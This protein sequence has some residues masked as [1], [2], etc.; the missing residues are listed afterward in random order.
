MTELFTA[1]HYTNGV[2][3]ITPGTPSNNTEDAPSGFSSNDPGQETSYLAERVAAAVKRGDG[4]NGDLLSA[5]FGLSEEV[6]TNLT[7]AATIEQRGAQEMNT[8]LWQATL[9][10]FLLQML[11]VGETSD[12]PVTDDDIAWVRS[13]FIDFVRANGPLPAIRVG[14]QPYGVL[15]VTSLDAW[16]PP[17]GE[18]SQFQ[19]DG[20]LRD[21][22]IRLRDIWR[23]NYEDVPRLGRTDDSPTEKGIDKDLI[24]V[25]SMDGLSSSYS[26]R[27]LM[28]RHYLE[29]LL[30]FMSADYFLDI[31]NNPGPTEPPEEEAPELEEPDP[32]LQP[33]FRAEFIR[34]QREA[35]LAFQRRQRDRALA[36][37]RERATFVS[38]VNNKRNSINEWWN[39][40]ERLA[41]NVLPELGIT[42]RPRLAHGVFAPPVTTLTGALVQAD[43]SLTL[44][45]NYIEALLAARDLVKEVRFHDLSIEQ[46]P[47]HTLLHLLLRHSMLLEYTS[48]GS[49]LLI[50]RGLL[51]RAQRRE[52]ELVDLPVGHLML[53]VWRQMAT[54][55]TVTDAGEMEL[56]HYL[57]G[58]TPDGE[59]DL[60]R[61]PDLKQVSEFRASLAH[62]KSLPVDKLE[63][64]MAG[65]LDLC[66]HRLDA[67]ITSL[68][69]KRL[70]E[71][72]NANPTSVLFGGYGWVMNLKPADAQTRVTPPPEGEQD[73][74]FQSSNNAG[75][76]HTPSLTQ[77]S[78]VAILRSGHL[79]H[80]GA[81][82]QAPDDL[83]AIDLSSE[84][85]RLA[86]WLLD[87][88]RQ[89]Q[90]LGA[91]LG[92]RFER[93]LQEAGKPQFI[94][95]FRELAPL[96]ARKLEP[97]DPANPQPVE[98]IA[99]N[100]VVDGLALLRRLQKGKSTTPPQWTK[101]TIPFGQAVGEQKTILPPV[102][103]NNAD[104]QVLQTELGVLEEAVD[105]VSDALVAES[106]YQ[107]VRGNPLRAASTVDS[108]AGGET[109]PPELEVVRTPRTGIAL[110]HRLITLFSGEPVL[111][112]GWP[113]PGNSVRAER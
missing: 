74:V 89:G 22:L 78:T 38:L 50:N 57:L 103:P 18:E 47:P 99:A 96:V 24:E 35:L 110:T 92:Y 108:I 33:R 56:G 88:V 19:R 106:V 82:N 64:L 62:L 8:A 13:H 34:R 4:S 79:T 10:Y 2:S 109:P 105:A 65:T 27:N 66:S 41:T 45:P 72:R 32:D 52:P 49:R 30:V 90:P 107:V 87:G 12:S 46:P 21:F 36:F 20:V 25:L 6:F 55:I 7:D 26:M 104:F 97:P 43:Q 94:A 76:V 37:A 98:A 17:T 112:P 42:W 83:L 71:L 54:K 91:L 61:E 84:R 101:D 59:P 1:H 77:A 51:T 40:Q 3:F 11:G 85:V 44:S 67:W 95:P 81:T 63:K 23:R 69:T 9:G 31:W 48:A 58:S 53:T 102:D 14:R 15:P 93:R 68:A 39:A 111:S 60:A 16:K 100:N 29:H 70:T 113:S 80:A 75:F 86:T 5:A 28:G 73:P